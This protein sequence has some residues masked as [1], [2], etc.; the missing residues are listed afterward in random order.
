[1]SIETSFSSETLLNVPDKEGNIDE[2]PRSVPHLLL[3][4]LVL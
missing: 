1:M 3:D 4:G 2:N